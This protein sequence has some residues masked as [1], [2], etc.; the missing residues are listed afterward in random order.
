HAGGVPDPRLKVALD[1]GPRPRG[2]GLGREHVSV[3]RSGDAPLERAV[4]NRRRVAVDLERVVAVDRRRARL[5]A[6]PRLVAADRLRASPVD[7]QRLGAANG[8]TVVAA[9]RGRAVAANHL[10]QISLRVHED[11]LGTRRILE[12]QLIEPGTPGRALR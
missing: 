11:L 2:A 1:V 10:P 6:D 12:A 8:L 9:D 4:V 5:L 3:E 7:H